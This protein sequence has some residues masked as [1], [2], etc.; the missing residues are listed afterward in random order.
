M[1]V[2]RRSINV[3]LAALDIEQRQLAE[4]MGYRPAYVTNV[5]NGQTPV[6]AAFRQAFG[7]AVAELLLGQPDPAP[8]RYPAQPLRDLVRRRAAAADS[9]TRFYEDLGISVHSLSNRDVLP[10]ALVDRLCCA[11][12][13]HPTSIYGPNGEVEDES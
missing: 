6:S 3:L 9:R 7:D 12:G 11:L 10:G 8:D 4:L 2:D 5:L 13:V 1:S